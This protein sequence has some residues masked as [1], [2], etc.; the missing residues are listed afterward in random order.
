MSRREIQGSKRGRDR[1]GGKEGKEERGTTLHG[2]AVFVLS[3]LNDYSTTVHTISH[4]FVCGK[5]RD[6]VL[7]G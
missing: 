5:L 4:V 7:L 1:E 6:P 2:L 3:Q